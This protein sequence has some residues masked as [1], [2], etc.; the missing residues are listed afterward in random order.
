MAIIRVNGQGS[1]SQ[2]Y[3]ELYKT[4]QNTIMAA[5]DNNVLPS[6]ESAHVISRPA[7]EDFSSI[8]GFSAQDLQSNFVHLTQDLKNGVVPTLSRY[9]AENFGEQNVLNGGDVDKGRSVGYATAAMEANGDK[10]A[11]LAVAIL[12]QSFNSVRSYY[13]SEDASAMLAGADVT[14]A[15]VTNGLPIVPQWAAEEIRQSIATESFD[16]KVTDQWRYHSYAIAMSAAKQSEFGS[17]WYRTQMLTPDN[18]G[19]ILSIRRNVCWDGYMMS[20]LAG[21][22]IAE[23]LKTNINV[24]LL[25]YTVTETE[26]VE[27]KPVVRPGTNDKFFVDP[28]LVAPQPVTTQGTPYNTNFLSFTTN[29]EAGNLI[30]LGQTLTVCR[31]V[32][33]TRPTPWIATSLSVK[34]W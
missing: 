14:P 17:L 23:D 10:Q 18:A 9:S 16:E 26:T 7:T 19:F 31:K 8:A 2:G 6:M 32:R 25:D 4:V 22:K 24:G 3:A 21:G 33:R 15:L 34:S 20:D 27:L 5:S 28:T 11:S 29:G 30:N 1:K 13:A 12:A